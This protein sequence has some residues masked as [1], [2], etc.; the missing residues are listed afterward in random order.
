MSSNDSR[1]PVPPFKRKP[2]MR[3]KKALGDLASC[4]YDLMP[5]SWFAGLASELD[6]EEFWF[7]GSKGPA[8]LDLIEQTFS[9]RPHKF[10]HLIKDI[11]A[12]GIQYRSLKGEEVTKQEYEKIAQVAGQVG[13]ELE[14]LDLPE[15]MPRFPSLPWVTDEDFAAILFDRLALHPRIRQVSEELF[16]DRHYSEAI[17]AAYRELEQIVREKSGLT[18]QSGRRLMTTAFNETKPV[19]RLN[20]LVSREDKDEQEG[21][22]FLFMGA[23]TGIRNPKAH[24]RVEQKDVFR[25]IEYLCFA[26]LLAKRVDE[27]TKSSD[28]T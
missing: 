25:T 14:D 23:T 7:G 13:V 20:D 1:L 16:K 2:T 24:K 15:E 28:D 11:I 12:T 21:F 27:S 19:L 22:K 18:D 10:E 17:F 8:I 3:Q 6:L 26:S 4:F 5:A 9:T